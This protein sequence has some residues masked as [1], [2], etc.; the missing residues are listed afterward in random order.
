M[1]V[2]ILKPPFRFF[3]LGG[4]SR[5]DAFGLLLHWDLRGNAFVP[6]SRSNSIPLTT[7]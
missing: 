6:L 7:V 5:Y 2:A 3:R 4:E 1:D